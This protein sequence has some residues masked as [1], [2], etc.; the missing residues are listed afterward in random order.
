MNLSLNP[1]RPLIVGALGLVAA[2]TLGFAATNTV[3]GSYAGD[4]VGSVSGY[5][6]T[7]LHYNLDGANPNMTTS[8]TFNIN[9]VLTGTSTKRISFDNGASWI[10]AINCSGNNPVTC[11][12]AVSVQAITSVRIVAA[13]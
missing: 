9:P 11:T 4:G 2:A 5:N 6:V 1:R 8:I 10:P 13:D 12:A 7:N 3:S